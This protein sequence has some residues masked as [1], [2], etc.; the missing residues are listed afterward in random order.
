MVASWVPL[1]Q[2]YNWDMAWSQSLTGKCYNQNTAGS[3]PYT[4]F[5][6]PC[7]AR[8]LAFP[9]PHLMRVFWSSRAP[10]EPA[11]APGPITLLP[12]LPPLWA[13]DLATMKGYSGP[14]GWCE[15]VLWWLKQTDAYDGSTSYLSHKVVCKN[16][17]KKQL[18]LPRLW[19]ST[20]S[21]NSVH[22]S[23]LYALLSFLTVKM[24]LWSRF[25]T[26]HRLTVTSINFKKILLYEKTPSIHY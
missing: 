26:R 14:T 8:D 22:S 17:S 13:T 20:F 23:K 7:G 1:G 9:G 19:Q 21:Q 6:G 15:F 4:T 2:T 12:L 25:W 11:R 5:L 18:T 10:L 24:L 16:K 3:W